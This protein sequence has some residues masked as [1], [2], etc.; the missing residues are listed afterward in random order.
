MPA[1]LTKA[2][3]PRQWLSPEHPVEDII[4]ESMRYEERDHAEIREQRD[5]NGTIGQ[6]HH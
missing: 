3:E 6:Q 5:T 4:C 1:L 2:I